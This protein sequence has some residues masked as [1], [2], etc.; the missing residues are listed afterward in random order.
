MT[1]VERLIAALYLEC[2]NTLP[3][4]ET[5]IDCDKLFVSRK[6]FDDRIKPHSTLG[7]LQALGELFD[8]FLKASEHAPEGTVDMLFSHRQPDQ[9]WTCRV[10]A[11]VENGERLLIFTDADEERIQ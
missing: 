6:V 2:S 11:T 4:L 5:P 3:V 9:V 8:R 7:P 1:R 10:E